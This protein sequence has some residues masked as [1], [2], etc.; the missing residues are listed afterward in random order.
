MSKRSEACEFDEKTRAYIKRR[1]HNRCVICG[2]KEGL[3]VMHIFV[4]RSHGGLGVKE[5]GC[6]GCIRCH[7]IMDNPI[8][9]TQNAQSKELIAYCKQYL[10][11]KEG[12]N[13][14]AEFIKSIRYR[15]Y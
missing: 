15:K 2:R 6:L 5:N 14:D 12:I 11:D 13:P 3:Q 10:I 9:R 4:N 7:R 1:D 8:G